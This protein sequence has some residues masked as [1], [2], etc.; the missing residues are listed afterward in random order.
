LLSLWRIARFLLYF[1]IPP[2]LPGVSFLDSSIVKE[3]VLYQEE[4]GL[5]VC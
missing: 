2:P 1:Q 3:E 4:E 5:L